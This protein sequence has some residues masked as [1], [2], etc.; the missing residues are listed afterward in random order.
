MYLL[1]VK[2]LANTSHWQPD[3][4]AAVPLSSPFSNEGLTS[5]L[6]GVLPDEILQISAVFRNCP[7]LKFRTTFLK[8]MFSSQR[9]PPST[10]G[11]CKDIK[12]PTHPTTTGYSELQ[13]S[14][15]CSPCVYQV[16]VHAILTIAGR[17]QSKANLIISPLPAS[18]MTPNAPVSWYPPPWQSPPT[19]YQS[20]SV[21]LIDVGRNNG[22]SLPR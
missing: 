4:L 16:P 10:S 2:P 20:R 18:Q 3:M 17:R 9:S 13:S 5:Q 8:A 12:V 14:P 19:L 11:Q 7:L 6:L 15:S 22:M 21:F 1:S